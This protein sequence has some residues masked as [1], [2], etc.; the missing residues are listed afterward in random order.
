MELKVSRY[1]FHVISTR[2]AWHLNVRMS[3]N[4]APGQDK[5]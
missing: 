3:G 4:T 1:N 5:T 2:L